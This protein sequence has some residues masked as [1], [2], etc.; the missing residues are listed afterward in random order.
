VPYEVRS[1]E[2]DGFTPAKEAAERLTMSPDTLFKT[3]IVRGERNGVVL[4]LVPGDQTLSLRKLAQQMGDKRAEMVDPS[5]I[6]RLT[7]FV[8][9]G[10][11]PLGSRRAYPVFM[12]QTALKHPKIAV[13]AG[14]R[15][16]ML[17]L[18]PSDLIAVVKGT[19]ADILE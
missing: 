12:D 11:S 18:S 14:V 10:V 5:E 13:S 6:T 9:G 2:H 19:T 4:A 15:G 7:G 3:L 1:F 16:L 8:K 17:L